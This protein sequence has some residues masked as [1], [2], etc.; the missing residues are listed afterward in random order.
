[1]YLL[2]QLKKYIFG[3]GDP[4][5]TVRRGKVCG[6]KQ[7]IFLASAEISKFKIEITTLMKLRLPTA[8]PL[9]PFQNK[10]GKNKIL[11]APFSV[12]FS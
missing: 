7:V 10:K 4:L 3:S 12:F 11:G 1:M 5:E 6:P 8:K 2:W 9:K